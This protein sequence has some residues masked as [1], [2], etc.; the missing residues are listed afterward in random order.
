[1]E[2]IPMVVLSVVSWIIIQKF[3]KSDAGKAVSDLIATS[4][5][6]KEIELLSETAQTLKENSS[7]IDEIVT[8]KTSLNKLRREGK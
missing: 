4:V 6:T 5:A 8:F 2:I 7:T 3:T 1:M